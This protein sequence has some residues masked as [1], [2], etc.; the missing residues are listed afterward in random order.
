MEIYRKNDQIHFHFNAINGF[1]DYNAFFKNHNLHN[2]Y[3]L[4]QVSCVYIHENKTRL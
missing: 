4:Q 1:I 2:H 3:H